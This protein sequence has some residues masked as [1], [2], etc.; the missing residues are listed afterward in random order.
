MQYLEKLKILIS[1][2]TY[3]QSKEETSRFIFKENYIGKAESKQEH[4]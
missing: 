3:T 4:N 2:N 1:I